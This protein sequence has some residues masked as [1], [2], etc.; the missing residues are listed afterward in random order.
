MLALEL[1]KPKYIMNPYCFDV[2]E[3]LEHI[4]FI[5]LSYNGYFSNILGFLIKKNVASSMQLVLGG[6][7]SVPENVEIA[8]ILVQFFNDIGRALNV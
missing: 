7:N 8:C 3:D 5:C 1:T 4:F 2:E 6:F